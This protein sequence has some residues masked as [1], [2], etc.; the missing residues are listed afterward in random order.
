MKDL[1]TPSSEAD[2]IQMLTAEPGRLVLML[3]GPNDR[4]LLSTFTDSSVYLF[5]GSGG[6]EG[7][8]KTAQQIYSR[9]ISR[10]AF[11]VDRDYDDF[12]DNIITYPPNA[13]V[14]EHH[15][16]FIDI[17]ESNFDSL[18]RVTTLM[19]SNSNHV[20]LAPHDD[21]YAL[22]QEV[23]D[24]AVR[25]AFHKAI[26]RIVAAQL[27][28]DFN[29]AKFSF[30]SYSHD[31]VTAALI[32]ND[33]ARCY[34]G[35]KVLPEDPLTL[36]QQ[37]VEEVKTL[38]FIPIGDHDLIEAIRSILK[39]DYSICHNETHFRDAFILTLQSASLLKARWC[40]DLITW[41]KQ[42]DVELF[43]KKE[44]SSSDSSSLRLSYSS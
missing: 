7:V 34:R 35:A 33:L 42:F 8:L 21:P 37:T 28:I 13:I 1:I 2:S 15:D 12:S 22:G 27:S 11:V 32:Y 20:T 9:G 43:V 44:S 17:A 26:V 25:L 3:E 30:F 16:C 23:V 10:A 39:Q 19:L 38:P 31:E 4:K 6:K 36:L 5:V 41:S 24:S 18:A 40:N 29:F 14:S